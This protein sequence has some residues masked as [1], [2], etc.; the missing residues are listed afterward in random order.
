M[1]LLSQNG[2]CVRLSVEIS[3]SLHGYDIEGAWAEHNFSEDN[4]GQ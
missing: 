1:L 4:A 3:I 2:E